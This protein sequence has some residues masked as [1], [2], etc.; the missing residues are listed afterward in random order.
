M[1]VQS[2]KQEKKEPVI[3]DN[4]LSA[5]EKEY[6]NSLPT[7]SLLELINDENEKKEK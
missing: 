4:N 7:E 3:L 6:L 2:N 1:L 5:E